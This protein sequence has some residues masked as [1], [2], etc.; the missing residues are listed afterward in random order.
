MSPTAA[1]A[2]ALKERGL[3]AVLETARRAG[4][5]CALRLAQELEAMDWDLL[6]RQRR[7]LQAGC[8][9]VQVEGVEA[10]ELLPASTSEPS[11]RLA[12]AEQRGWDEL[13]AGR[14]AAVTLAGGQASRLGFDG[15]K[16]AFALGP[17]TGASLF[18]I[19]AG[20]VSRL[21]AL[22]GAP[23]P[24][25]LMTGP[26]NDQATRRYFERRNWFGLG[27][28]TVHFACQGLLPAL[29]PEGEL[30]LAA[31]DRLFRNPDGHGGL[32]RALA[33][34]GLI[35]RLQEQGIGTLFTCQVDNPLVRIADPAFLGFHL[36][37]GARMSAKAVIKTEP[38]EKVGVLILRGGVLECIEY[39]DLPPA[40][41]AERAADGGL[42]LR[43]GNIAIHLIEAAFAREMAVAELPL[44]RALKEVTALDA[45]GQPAR[46]SAVKFESFIFDALPQAGA[47]R[48]L[49]QQAEREEEF[50]PVKNPGGN[51]S[52]ASARA[53]MDARARRWL[54]AA[55]AEVQAPGLLELQPG[56]ALSAADLAAQRGQWELRSGRLVARKR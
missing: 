47:G 14:L 48:A 23:V 44:H 1:A 42:L 52:P 32:F 40:L 26:E 28:R 37:G 22:A 17:V 4:A 53:A 41:Q 51:D 49:V 34:G 50:A 27:A 16:G 25:I 39:S 54:R 30:L 45:D 21:R 5:D 24:W 10:P 11:A 33:R 9:P 56:L 38:E 7:A 35:E 18:Q 46:R 31:P 13:R 43:A 29:S 3:E 8:A 55:G 15:P 20:Q 19:L 36:Q 2:A 6:D 12:A